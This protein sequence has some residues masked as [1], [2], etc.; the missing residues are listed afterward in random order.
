MRGGI[1]TRQSLY[2]YGCMIY[3][4]EAIKETQIY[5]R[6]AAAKQEH[7]LRSELAFKLTKVRI[8]NK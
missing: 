3:F 5:L 8:K 7:S 2:L 1:K 6:T 4:Y